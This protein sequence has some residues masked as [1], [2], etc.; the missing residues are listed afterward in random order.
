MSFKLDTAMNKADMNGIKLTGDMKKVLRSLPLGYSVHNPETSTWYSIVDKIVRNTSMIVGL[1]ESNPNLH[2]KISKVAKLLKAANKICETENVVKKQVIAKKFG[3][4]DSVQQIRI[5]LPSP[6]KR[7]LDRGIS[8][9]S[10]IDTE[11][12]DHY[13]ANFR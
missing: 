10:G 11:C 13:P 9:S 3:D 7:L 4:F 6:Q 1:K 5:C 12:K 2:K 8:I